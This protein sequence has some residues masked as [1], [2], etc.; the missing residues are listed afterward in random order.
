MQIEGNKAD[1]KA[2]GVQGDAAK[3]K[4]EKLAT[5]ELPVGHMTGE[6]TDIAGTT[7][8]VMQVEGDE[9]DCKRAVPVEQPAYVEVAAGQQDKNM[10]VDVDVEEKTVAD[11]PPLQE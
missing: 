5:E 7:Y 11:P 9:A 10:N 4:M 8:S 6:K 2:V 1:G 3:D